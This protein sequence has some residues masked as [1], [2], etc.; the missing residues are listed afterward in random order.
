MATAIPAD[1]YVNADV[2]GRERAA[3]FARVWHCVGSVGQW[4]Q[5]GDNLAVDIAGFPLVFVRDAGT[6]R[7]FHNVCRHRGGPL[8]W[9]GPGHGS[10]LVCRYHGWSYRL[11]GQLQSA[12]DFGAN[13]ACTVGRDLVAVRTE[14]WRGLVFATLDDSAEPLDRWLAGFDEACGDAPLETYELGPRRRHVVAANWKVYAENY[15]EGYHIPLV[16]PGLARQI[17]SRR[18]DVEVNGG[19]ARHRAP[20]RDG[21]V[22]AGVWLWRFPGLA[23]NLYPDGMC[24]ETAVPDGPHATRI[25]YAFSFAPGTDPAVVDA[26]VTSSVAIL[27]EDRVICEAVQRSMASGLYR[28]GLLSPRHERGVAAVQQL[29]RDALA[30]PAPP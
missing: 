7:G 4:A 14:T 2:Y 24:V 10:S 18:Y 16:H 26:A 13:P 20:T 27:D 3:I 23:L 30:A 19:T 15:M 6:V 22:T 12:R 28:G 29:V 1:W 25:E 8:V 11:D 21:A 17:D 9:D 5:S